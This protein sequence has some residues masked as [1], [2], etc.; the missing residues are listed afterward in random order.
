MAPLAVPHGRCYSLNPL[1]AGD[2]LL[3]LCRHKA[4]LQ[5]WNQAA[6]AAHEELEAAALTEALQQ[7]ADGRL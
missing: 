4:R 2:Q 3:D 1:R 7:L 6:I 5:R